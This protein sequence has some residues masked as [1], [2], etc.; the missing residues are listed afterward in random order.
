MI[1]HVQPVRVYYVDF[2][3]FVQLGHERDAPS[4]LPLMCVI[5]TLLSFFRCAGVTDAAPAADY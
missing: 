4:I 3:N 5:P 2:K 1:R